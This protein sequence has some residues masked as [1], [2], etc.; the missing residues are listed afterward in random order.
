MRAGPPSPLRSSPVASSSTFTRS[1]AAS[2]ISQS[3]SQSM[4]KNCAPPTNRSPASTSHPRRRSPS[5]KPLPGQQVSGSPAYAQLGCSKDG[6][7]FP[8]GRLSSPWS[9]CP[10]SSLCPSPRSSFL[11]SK[12]DSNAN[13][14]N[15]NSSTVA[16]TIPP[17]IDPVWSVSHNR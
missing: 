15:N 12:T 5:P 11:H 10:P 4:A 8:R 16:T 17:G 6:H 7:H 13:S 3:I 1:L 2:C 14:N 9:S